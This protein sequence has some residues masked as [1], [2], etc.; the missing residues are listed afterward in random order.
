ME[1]AATEEMERIALEIHPRRVCLVPE[2]RQ[3]LT[4]EGG[5]D[6]VAHRT[7]LKKMIRR[8]SAKKIEVSL[9]IDADSDQIRCAQSLGADTIELHTGRYA[10]AAGAAREQE[11]AK[12]LTRAAELAVELKLRLH[13]GHGLDYRNVGPVARFPAWKNSISDFPSSPA[14]CSSAWGRR[15]KK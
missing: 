9:F 14:P 8:L 11:L 4:T 13:A 10:L 12:L 3:E 1:M 6:V 15:S 7:S 5:L 2:K